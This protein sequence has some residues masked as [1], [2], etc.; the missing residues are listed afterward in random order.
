MS[1]KSRGLRGELKLHR[2]MQDSPTGVAQY[3]AFVERR[4][5]VAFVYNFTSLFPNLSLKYSSNVVL[6]TP[7][8]KSL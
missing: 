5:K 3:Q 2:A 6:L 1:W 4:V 7:G 8:N